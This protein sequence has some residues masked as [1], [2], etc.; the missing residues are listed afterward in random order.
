MTI[1]GKPTFRIRRQPDGSWTYS[2][3]AGPTTSDL[4]GGWSAV[5]ALRDRLDA[6]E[7]FPISS[8]Y[9]AFVEQFGEP[10]L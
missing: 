2:T 4:V 7:H 3:D 5:G 8:D 10:P 1:S 6:V 9:H